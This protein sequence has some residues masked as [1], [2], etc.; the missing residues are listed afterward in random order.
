MTDFEIVQVSIHSLAETPDPSEEWTSYFNLNDFENEH[1]DQ[2]TQKTRSKVGL[3]R[4]IVIYWIMSGEPW[5][6]IGEGISL[7]YVDGKLFLTN[8]SKMKIYYQSWIGNDI[9]NHH[10]STVVEVKPKMEGIAV[11][12]LSYFAEYLNVSPCN[13]KV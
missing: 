1:R 10:K 4:T 11:F 5:L 8:N 3:S 12:D 7:A 13:F 6:K 2:E 9:L